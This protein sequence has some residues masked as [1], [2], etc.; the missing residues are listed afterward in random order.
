[1]VPALMMAMMLLPAA[2]A[3]VWVLWVAIV[4][5]VVGISITHPIAVVIMAGAILQS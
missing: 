2:V 1:M 5:V 4:V 3:V